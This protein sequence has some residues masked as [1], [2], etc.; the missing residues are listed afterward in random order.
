M[1]LPVHRVSIV[2]LAFHGE[3]RLSHY[4]FT[5]KTSIVTLT[6]HIVCPLWHYH[7]IG[8]LFVHPGFTIPLILCPFCCY[9][10]FDMVS[11]LTLWSYRHGIHLAVTI[12]DFVSIQTSPLHGHCQCLYVVTSRAFSDTVPILTSTVIECQRSGLKKSSFQFAA[13]L[14]KPEFKDQV[15]RRARRRHHF[16]IIFVE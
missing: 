8:K 14:M 1:T 3:Y 6:F 13:M 7:S 15:S 2:T 5:E 10:S 16:G 12:L 4:H 9:H 11:I